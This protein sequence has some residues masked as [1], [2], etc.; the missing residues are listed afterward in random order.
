ME[1]MNCTADVR[2]D[3]CDIYAPTQFQTFAQING[4]KITGLKP[5]QVRVH[6]TYLGGGFGRRAESDF[7]IE[8]VGLLKAVGAP[9]EVTWA[10]EDAMQHDYYRPAGMWVMLRGL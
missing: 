8:A 1:P 6:T 3:G 5:E 7:I 2:A 10:R 4:A 9:V